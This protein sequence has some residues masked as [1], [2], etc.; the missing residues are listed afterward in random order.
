MTSDFEL[1]RSIFPFLQVLNRIA[2]ISNIIILEN[3]ALVNSFQ[4]YI[5]FKKYLLFS[6]K[7]VRIL[8]VSLKAMGF[9]ALFIGNC[10]RILGIGGAMNG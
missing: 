5:F 2:F 8:V 7:F 10:L 9:Y 4:G 3:S 1:F 6:L